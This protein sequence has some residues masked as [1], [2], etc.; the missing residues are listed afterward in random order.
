MSENCFYFF[1]IVEN[2]KYSFKFGQLTRYKTDDYHCPFC[3]SRYSSTCA[4]SKKR[5]IKNYISAHEVIE[6][7]NYL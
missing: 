2:K 7:S 3:C 6:E 4:A 1:R 5:S